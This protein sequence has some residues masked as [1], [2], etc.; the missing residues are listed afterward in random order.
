MNLLLF[1]KKLSVLI[2]VFCLIGLNQ[3]KAQ[4]ARNHAIKYLTDT[5]A[6]FQSLISQFKGKIVYV[7]I[8]AT[9]CS[10]CRQELQKVREI[11][12]FA[13]FAKKNDIVILYIC[14]DH[15]AK[16]WK[17]FITSNNLAGYHYLAGQALNN[18]F[19]TTYS[20]VQLRR[21]VMKRSF[22]LPRHLIIDQAGSITDSTAG[23][24]GNMDV[25]RKISKLIVRIS[26]DLE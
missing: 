20:S 2:I 13:D 16:G 18:D 26:P 21:G 1:R 23:A 7:D 5:S 24:Q 6:N 9:W 11:K 8:W 25:Y 22:Y 12:A 19:H 10:P 14:A 3:V 4:T 15:N 17:Q